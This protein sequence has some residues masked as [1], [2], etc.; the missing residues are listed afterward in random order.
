MPRGSLRAKNKLYLTGSRFTHSMKATRT[1]S[2]LSSSVTPPA[3]LIGTALSHYKIV[4]LIGAGGM[5][6]VYL[7][8]DE[9]LHRQVAIKVLAPGLLG[10]EQARRRFREEAL[11]LSRLNH[12]NIAT[13]HDFETIGD[14]DLLVM[15]YV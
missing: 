10:D 7:A 14:R 2:P 8:E 3:S 4:S 1:S 12:P 9:R 13:I 5:G 15:E 11:T 6:E